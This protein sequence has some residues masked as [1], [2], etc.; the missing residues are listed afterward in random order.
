[1]LKKRRPQQKNASAAGREEEKDVHIVCSAMERGKKGGRTPS[2][3][4]GVEIGRTMLSRSP[5]LEGEKGK[6]KRGMV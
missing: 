5:L 3:S 4:S 6:K 1:L 2:S